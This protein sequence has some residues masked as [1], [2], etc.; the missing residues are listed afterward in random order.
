MRALPNMTVVAVCDADEMIRFMDRTLDWPG[1]IYIRLAKG[2]APIVSREE[3]GFEIGKAIPMRLAA[4]GTSRVLL[5]STGVATTRALAA[6]ELMAAEGTECTV[7]HIHTIKPFDAEAVRRHAR[8][9][10]LVVSVEEHTIIGG[11]GSAM[12]DALVD[13]CGPRLPLIRRLG[14]HGVFA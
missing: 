8:E 13:S 5:V 4:A 14:M 6:A 12:T 1:P 9:V 2:F 10:S 3:L 11:L 7:L